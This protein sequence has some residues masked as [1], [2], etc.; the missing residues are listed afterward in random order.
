MNFNN[1]QSFITLAEE[2]NFRKAS[3]RLMITQPALSQQ[4]QQIE[5][6]LQATMFFRTKRHVRL[7]P[8]G[9]LFLIKSKELIKNIK[10]TKVLIQDIHNGTSGFLRIGATIPA[11]YILMPDII[12]EVKK[13]IPNVTIKIQ[14]MD[15]AIQE[16]ELRNNHIDIGLGHPPFEDKTLAAQNIAT[17]PFEVVMSKNCHLADKNPLCMKDLSEETL[18]LF[19]RRLAPLQ[20]DTILS[21]C[22]N[23]GFSPKKIIEVSP[24]QSI[25]AFAG[26]G[27]GI[28]FIA[29]KLQ[30]FHHPHV[31]YHPL[32][33]PRPTFTL[34]TIYRGED[35]S[36][37]VKTFNQC[38]L[39]I[40]Q[41]AK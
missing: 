18:I 37:L 38:A 30:Q 19:P 33:E 16:E 14:S 29:S 28:G 3:E 35:S 2:L 1:L 11:I 13:R 20:Y 15:T 34:G 4:I 41:M 25:I 7:T 21:L 12:R 10:E 26:T 6:E 5:N 31:I 27:L 22:L 23:S 9:E 32:M 17:I 36:P 8:A 39:M 40:G 24:A